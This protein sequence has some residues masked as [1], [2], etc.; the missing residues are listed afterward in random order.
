MIPS[1]LSARDVSRLT[2]VSTDTLRH[3][4]RLRLL[5]PPPRTPGGYR[6]YAPSAVDRVLMIQRAL[7]VGLSLRE[8]AAI[9]A[10]RARGGAP[11]RMVRAAVARRLAGLDQDI[12]ELTMMRAEIGQVLHDWDARL[13]TAPSGRPLGLLES[14][15]GRPSIDRA[16]ARRL[17]RAAES[18]V[19]GSPRG[20]YAPTRHRLP[21]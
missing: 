13:A 9:L 14:L 1:A 17:G 8:L 11:C 5:A 20:R 18:T 19:L 4:E 12:A 15:A 10:H 2:G 21:T 7:V 3:Y 16:R 6:R